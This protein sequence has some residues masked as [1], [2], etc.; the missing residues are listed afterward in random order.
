MLNGLAL[1]FHAKR[2][3]ARVSCE[4]VWRQSRMLIGLALESYAKRSSVRVSC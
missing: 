2:S 1:E 4:T 3:G